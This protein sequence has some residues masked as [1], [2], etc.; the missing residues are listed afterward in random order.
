MMAEAPEYR[1][2][3]WIFRL[4]VLKT[5][6]RLLLLS[7]CVAVAPVFLLAQEIRPVSPVS[8]TQASNLSVS[9]VVANLV[10]SNAERSKALESYT[11]RRTYRLDYHGFPGDLQSQMIVKVVYRAPST[12]KFTIVSESG[13]KL[14]INRV[15]H[16]LLESEEE[17]LNAKNRQEGALN[18]L[19]YDFTLI[20]FDRTSEGSCYV[21]SVR[22]KINNKF[23]YRGTIWVDATD[24][25]VRRI[26]AQPA[27]TPSFWTKKSQ[28]LQTYVKAGHFWMP[29]NN[30]TTTAVRFG[31]K[32]VL[33][34][35]Y[36][37]YDLSETLLAAT[38][39]Q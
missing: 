20:K 19:N 38:A 39:K 35:D 37:N 23:L 8:Q 31:G 24:F 36:D 28:I 34:I 21:L 12:K 33:N 1:H 26:E 14:L 22:P 27:K 16:K 7:L 25:A 2:E 4:N 10:A 17:A 13:S 30:H 32:A 15:L 9:Q 6:P 18:E 11:G 5:R 3:R 29:S